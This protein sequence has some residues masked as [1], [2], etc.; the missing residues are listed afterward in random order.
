MPQIGDDGDFCRRAIRVAPRPRGPARPPGHR[1]LI[2]AFT[3]IIG[4]A[5][6]DRIIRVLRPAI[7]AL[8]EENPGLEKIEKADK[9]IAPPRRRRNRN[10]GDL[11]SWA[12]LRNRVLA[13][14][15]ERALTPTRSTSCAIASTK[16][17]PKTTLSVAGNR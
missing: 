11:E 2:D 3:S 17:W 15:A 1:G 14:L 4:I 10:T 12:P 16:G 5:T 7:V 8:L 6:P 9:P 13:V